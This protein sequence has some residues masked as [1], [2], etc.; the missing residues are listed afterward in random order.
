[1]KTKLANKIKISILILIF[2]LIAVCKKDKD[3][4]IKGCNSFEYDGRTYDFTYS[5]GRCRTGVVS[6]SSQEEGGP[7]FWITC[8]D[9]YDPQVGPCMKSV[10]V[11]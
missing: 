4:V 3:P 7:K 9:D 8:E 10:W 1:M 11:D 6:F 2:S 5:Y